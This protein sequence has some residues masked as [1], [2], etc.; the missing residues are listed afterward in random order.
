L[1]KKTERFPDL[2]RD[3]AAKLDEWLTEQGKRRYGV[4]IPEDEYR[5]V[6]GAL[7]IDSEFIAKHGG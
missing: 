6:L 5:R 7:G 1:G 2:I 3:P 4:E